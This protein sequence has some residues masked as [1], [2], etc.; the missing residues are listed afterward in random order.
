MACDLS[1]G[2]RQTLRIREKFVRSAFRQEAAWFDGRGDPQE[3]PTLVANALA[4]ING[5][6]GRSVA[7]TF[8]NLLSAVGALA[9][10]LVLDPKL[11][12]RK[13]RCVS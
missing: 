5:A 9:I 11:V 7:D 6:I 2:E 13:D 12:G 8:A 4:R 3:L 1:E 10:S